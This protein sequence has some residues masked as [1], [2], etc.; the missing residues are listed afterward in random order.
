M[1]TPQRPIIQYFGGKW[2]LAPWIIEHF[3]VHTVYVEPYGGAASVLL[4]KEPS[5]IEVWNDLNGELV[6]LFRVLQDRAQSRE[7]LRMLRFTLWSRQENIDS[8]YLSPDPV[9]RARQYVTKTWQSIGYGMS[10]NSFRSTTNPNSN[11]V[12]Q[13]VKYLRE[14]SS[15]IARMRGVI[16]ESEPAVQVIDRYD[17]AGS[18]FYVDPPYVTDTRIKK[19]QYH[20]EMTDDDHRALAVVLHNVAGFV[21]LSGYD[22]DLYRELYA[23]WRAVAK[24]SQVNGGKMKTEM[25]WMNPR[26]ADAQR[27]MKLF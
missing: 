27:Q 13:W 5:K 16:I 19:N 12:V 26:C 3:P 9:E 15:Y 7:L 8:F 21:V 17:G 10:G 1:T 20:A 14:F 23:D 24:K 25:L 18:L 11:P 2:R 22:C 4:R 6:N